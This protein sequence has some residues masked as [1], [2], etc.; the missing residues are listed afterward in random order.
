MARAD[1]DGWT[2]CWW[3]GDVV[4]A[5]ATSVSPRVIQANK[6]RSLLVRREEAFIAVLGVGRK[7]QDTI[8]EYDSRMAMWRMTTTPTTKK[9]KK[10]PRWSM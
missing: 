9:K 8:Q 7:W 10:I 6:A 3:R 4:K 2:V 5:D 1:V